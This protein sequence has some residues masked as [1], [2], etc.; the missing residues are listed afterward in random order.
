M[1]GLIVRFLQSQSY[2]ITK[3]AQVIM[4]MARTGIGTFFGETRADSARH[5][6]EKKAQFK[7]YVYECM[8]QGIAPHEVELG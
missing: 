4:F 5:V 1:D 8:E 3:D 2:D 6:R 7:E